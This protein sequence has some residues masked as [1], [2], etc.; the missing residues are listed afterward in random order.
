MTRRGF[1][2]ITA[3]TGAGLAFGFH[4]RT[5]G[6]MTA[7]L[8]SARRLEEEIIVGFDVGTSKICAAVAKVRSEGIISIMGMGRAPSRG[9]RRGQ[10]VD[11]EWARNS[12]MKALVNAEMM[13]NVMIQNVYLG[14]V[15]PIKD[16]VRCLKEVPVA[17][18]DVV[19]NPLASAKAVLDADKKNLGALVIDIGGGSTDYLVYMDGAVRQSGSVALGGDPISREIASCFGIPPWRA[20]RLKIEEGS[21]TLGATLPGKIVTLKS[22]GGF[23]PREVERETLN[24][25]IQIR[26][27]QMLECVKSRLDI[28]GVP[29]NSLGAGVQLTGG[30]SLLRG[31]DELARQV[32]GIP[33]YRARV[34][35]VSGPASILEDPRYSCAIGLV[36][37]SHESIFG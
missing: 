28:S 12:V 5:H 27:R 8:R 35:G 17:V 29:L 19:L 25:I 20:E 2:S 21:V 11:F 13:N 18:D 37:H 4:Q 31:I 26:T 36:K 6:A 14:G 24:S 23:P 22:D 16:A 30:C 34:N 10:I 9:V 7:Y 3:F 1:L 32:F 33:A 15:A